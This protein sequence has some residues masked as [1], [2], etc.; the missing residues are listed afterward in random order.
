[1]Q[2]SVNPLDFSKLSHADQ[3]LRQMKQPVKPIETS[4]VGTLPCYFDIFTPAKL[5]DKKKFHFSPTPSP[6]EEIEEIDS[7][8]DGEGEEKKGVDI[9]AAERLL[10]SAAPAGGRKMSLDLRGDGKGMS[11]LK[12]IGRSFKF[13]QALVP[14]KKNYEL[15]GE[16]SRRLDI[17]VVA[18]KNID[19]A[20]DSCE[21]SF[22]VVGGA[23]Q[24]ET[25]SVLYEEG[26]AAR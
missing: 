20:G 15:L 12:K 5:K 21:L 23:T 1:M 19:I 25:K 4:G 22:T 8:D 13:S 10:A 16:S 26:K 3:Q 7:G 2:G 11:K 24:F 6:R 14:K 17:S 18:A 9:D